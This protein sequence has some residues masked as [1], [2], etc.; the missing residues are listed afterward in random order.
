MKLSMTHF[1]IL[2]FPS[3]V[4]SSHPYPSSNSIFS[5][6]TFSYRCP[7][8]NPLRSTSFII[9]SFLFSFLP[10]PLP[11]LSISLC[12]SLSLP[13][14]FSFSLSISLPLSL[15]HLFFSSISRP[16]YVSV[17]VLYLRNCYPRWRS[18]FAF[19]GVR[20]IHGSLLKWVVKPTAAS[21]V[22][23]SSL[24]YQVLTQWFRYL[25]YLFINFFLDFLL[26]YYF[27]AIFIISIA[28][29][30]DWTGHYWNS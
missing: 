9:C 17:V 7:R 5:L 6:I 18:Q 25:E 10:S 27:R 29:Y 12:H 22:L 28:F 19:Y 20:T 2:L 1:S 23:M 11:S 16:H 21:L 26:N 24:H 4:F 8:S 30:T 3:Q 13:P 14:P 15:S